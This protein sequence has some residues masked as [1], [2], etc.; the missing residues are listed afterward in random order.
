MDSTVR[1]AQVAP[2]ADLLTFTNG[3][4]GCA[5]SIVINMKQVTAITKDDYQPRITF[6]LVKDYRTVYFASPK[7]CNDAYEWVIQNF[8]MRY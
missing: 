4:K 1:V 3:V 6:S 7:E 2:L 5:T 8:T